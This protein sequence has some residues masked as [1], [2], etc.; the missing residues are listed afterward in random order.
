MDAIDGLGRELEAEAART[1][2]ER[3]T[4][5]L[6]QSVVVENQSGGGGIVGCSAG[7]FCPEPGVQHPRGAAQQ[8][9]HAAAALKRFYRHY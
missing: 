8:R 9:E 6:G 3:L 2:A 1:I 4:T 5:S 7:S